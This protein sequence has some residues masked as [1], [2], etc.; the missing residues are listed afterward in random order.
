MTLYEVL[1]Y[2]PIVAQNEELGILITANG[3]YLNFWIAESHDQWTNTEC[4]SFDFDGNKC[5][6]DL[7]L[8]KVVEKAE[9][10]LDEVLENEL[11]EQNA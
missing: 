2:G 9:Q 8:S 10:W 11:N 4:R 3:S 5:I 1:E 7:S 6:M